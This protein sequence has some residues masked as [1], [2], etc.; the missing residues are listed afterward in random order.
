MEQVEIEL[1]IELFLY[2]KIQVNF[3][4]SKFKHIWE[5]KCYDGLLALVKLNLFRL[6]TA[7]HLVDA[8]G[9]NFIIFCFIN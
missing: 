8:S 5:E 3:R 2:S 6:K 1:E 9:V 4:I 7:R